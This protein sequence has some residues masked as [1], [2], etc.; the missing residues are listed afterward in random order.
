MKI[1]THI[2]AAAYLWESIRSYGYI[3]SDSIGSPITSKDRFID[4]ARTYS[5]VGVLDREETITREAR[6]WRWEQRDRQRVGCIN[7]KTFPVLQVEVYGQR[8][9]ETMAQ[10]LK[11]LE[12]RLRQFETNLE[13]SVELEI[14]G[15]A[16]QYKE[17][18][19]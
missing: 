18:D 2:N 8:H 12:H 19:I 14:C 13:L 9:A 11:D 6:W 4:F 7:L 3:P 10:I 15:S 5:R 1:T 16:W 17:M